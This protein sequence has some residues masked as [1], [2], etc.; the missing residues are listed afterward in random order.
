[1]SLKRKSS[2]D[3]YGIFNSAFG[4]EEM[5]L[6]VRSFFAS[7]LLVTSTFICSGFAQ[8]DVAQ[9]PQPAQA[10]PTSGDVMRDRIARSKAFIAVR[11][12]NAAIFELENIRRESGDPAVQSVANVLLMN[13]FL[14]LGD[15]KRAQGLLKELFD[16][17]KTTRPG[18]ANNYTAAA[19]QVIRTARAQAERYRSLGLNPSDRTLP[20]EA[21]NDLERMRETLEVV[22]A[23]QKEIGKDQRRT[24]EAMATLEEAAVSRSLL[25]RDDYDARRWKDE[26]ADTREALANSRSQVLSAVNDASTQPLAGSQPAQP[27]LVQ[28][29]MPGP[30]ATQ[31][32]PIASAPVI[33]VPSAEPR[34]VV[35]EREVKVPSESTIA[36]VEKKPEPIRN[37]TPEDQPATK[38]NDGPLEVG[39]LVAYATRQQQPVYPPAAKSIRATGVVKVEVTVNEAG[40]VAEIQNAT[41]PALLQSAAKDAVRKWRFKPF[42]RDGQPVRATGYVSFNFNL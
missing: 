11:N 29:S 21:L 1:M 14:E 27:A 24:A 23:Q 12:Y 35:R 42:V 19:G 8:G 5:P 39:S 3:L 28:S 7:V 17:Q 20:L 6:N 22:I 15:F 34:P 13:S 38:A 26:V 33:T 37:D 4:G 32:L 9:A 18:A 16:Q 36:V 10:P 41:G 2:L 31:N 25:A 30:A 40:E